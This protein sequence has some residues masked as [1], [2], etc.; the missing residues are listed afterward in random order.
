MTDEI[1][2]KYLSLRGD[3]TRR[4]NFIK[5]NAFDDEGN[6]M[7]PEVPLSLESMR[8]IHETI[9]KLMNVEI[10]TIEAQMKAL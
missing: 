5:Y 8:F 4:S 3:Y 7:S 6:Y 10:E 1:M 2:D 9:L